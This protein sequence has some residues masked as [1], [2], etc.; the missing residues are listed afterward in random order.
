MTAAENKDRLSRFFEE[1]INQYKP[2]VFEELISSDYVNHDL[3]APAPG[4]E[5]LK[6]VVGMFRAAFPDMH[7]AVEDMVAEGDKVVSRG[8]MTGTHRGEFMRIP[9]TGRQV[10]VSYTDVWRVENDKFVENWVRL[11]MLGMLRQLGVVPA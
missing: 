8:T 3:P 6:Q 1:G 2:E 10:A 4:A 9:A 7:V 11:D 5:G